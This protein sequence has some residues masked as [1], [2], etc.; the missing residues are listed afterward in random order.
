MVRVDIP[1]EL[2]RLGLR[3]GGAAHFCGLLLWK[4]LLEKN[5]QAEVCVSFFD[6]EAKAP[7]D[8]QNGLLAIPHCCDS[9]AKNGRTSYE[10]RGSPKWTRI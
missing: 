3:G 2:G 5:E 7:R 4:T 9:I 6:V 10:R 8:G 1:L